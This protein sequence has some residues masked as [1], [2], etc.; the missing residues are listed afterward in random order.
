M[1]D[2]VCY[3]NQCEKCFLTHNKETSCEEAEYKYFI[4]EVKRLE[5][6]GRD[7][8]SRARQCRA[9]VQDIIDSGKVKEKDDGEDKA[10]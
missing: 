3:K 10:L 8:L 1:G 7:A 9:K 5:Y 6:L 4:Q 2:G